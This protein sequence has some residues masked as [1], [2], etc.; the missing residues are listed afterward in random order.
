MGD[1]KHK[2]SWQ[3][4]TLVTLPGQPAEKRVWRKRRGWRIFWLMLQKYLI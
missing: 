3:K 2:K 4:D 1:H